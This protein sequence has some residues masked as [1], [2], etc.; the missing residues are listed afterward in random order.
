MLSITQNYKNKDC[1]KSLGEVL[2]QLIDLD[3]IVIGVGT[4]SF[5][6]DAL[7]PIVSTLLEKRQIP[8][9][10]F[11]TLTSTVNFNNLN[12]NIKEIRTNYPKSK[13]LAVDACLGDSDTIGN[14]VIRN[15]GINAGAG[16]KKKPKI[17]GDVSIIGI[18][19]DYNKLEQLQNGHSKV[20]LGFVIEL[21]FVI[22]DSICWALNCSKV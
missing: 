3:T 6:F 16:A 11:G 21:A 7:G 5:I 4:D 1:Y 18:V 8:I 15:S 17:V 9:K 2:K 22:T 19:D 20:K 13:I 12:E 14:I 10:V